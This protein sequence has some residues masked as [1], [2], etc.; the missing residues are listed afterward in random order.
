MKFPVAMNCAGSPI[1]FRVCAP[2]VTVIEVSVRTGGGVDK[3]TV[4]VA[5]PVTPFDV[6]VMVAV[7]AP[8]AVAIPL[9]FTVTTPGALEDHC[10]CPVKSCEGGFVL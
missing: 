6:A 2:G 8:T 4:T 1:E 7:P 3:D 10:A 5:L 9:G